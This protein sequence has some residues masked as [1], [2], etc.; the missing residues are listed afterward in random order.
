MTFDAFAGSSIQRMKASTKGAWLIHHANKLSSVTNTGGGFEQVSFAGKCGVLLSAI[1]AAQQAT[2]TNTK[3]EAL[4]KAAGISTRLELP[5]IL[6]E[7]K[8][9]H[10]I[11]TGQNGIEV[12]GLTTAKTLEHTATIFTEASPSQSESASLFLAETVS[13][14]PAD[15]STAK[16]QVQD[17]YQLSDDECDELLGAS[18][19][20]GF[21]DFEQVDS[22]TKLYF[23]GNLF[24]RDEA[25]KITAVIASLSAADQKLMIEVRDELGKCG[26]VPVETVKAKLGDKLFAKL[27]S[28]GAYDVNVLGNERGSFSF[29]T[30]PGAFKKFSDSVVDDAFDL[31]K[32]FV[33]SLTYGMTKSEYGRGRIT[34][35]K[36]LMEKLIRGNWVGPATA[37][38]HDYKVLELKGVIQVKPEN[39]M[40]SMKLLKPDVGAIALQVILDGE[41]S[42]SLATQ[43]PGASVTTYSAPENVRAVRRKNQTEPMKREVGKLLQH[44]RTGRI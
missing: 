11:S 35:I 42:S 17:L 38:G 20:I 39:G 4:A 26:C 29:V 9:Q 27:H 36:A 32:A 18:E 6:T 31:A 14:L 8:R 37:I 43:L 7:L 41:A 15:E 12:L 30:Q 19:Q 34:M 25:K 2:L 10:L 3:I 5:M 22:S 33:S 40:F 24:R 44:L 1:S 16:E 13:E 28:I 23:N 21:V